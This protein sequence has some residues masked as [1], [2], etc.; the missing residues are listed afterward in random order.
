MKILWLFVFVVLF[1]LLLWVF[2]PRKYF[3]FPRLDDMQRFYIAL[4]SMQCEGRKMP[5][6]RASRQ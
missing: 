4:A 1:G 6:R 5:N 2:V 3:S